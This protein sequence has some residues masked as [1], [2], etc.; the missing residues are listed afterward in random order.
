M[1]YESINVGVLAERL[2]AA[3]K[4]AKITQE[5]AAD[6]LGMSRPTFIAIE[7]ASDGRILKSSSNWLSFTSAAKQAGK[8]RRR[9][10]D[11]SAPLA[12]GIE[13]VFRWRGRAG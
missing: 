4:A 3:R 6:F 8:K 9:T 7:K 12:L 13:C 11:R 1:S 10:A 2:V 5:V